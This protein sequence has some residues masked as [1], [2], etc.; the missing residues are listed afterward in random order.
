MRLNVV[1]KYHRSHLALD[2]ATRTVLASCD[3][4]MALWHLPD[5][6][7]H[8][9][10][11]LS[12]QF[13]TIPRW[14]LRAILPTR[15]GRSLIASD[16][17]QGELR[18]WRVQS[19]ARTGLR[20]AP[21]VSPDARADALR[22]VA[23]EGNA[24][25]VANA[26]DGTA[27]GPSVDLPQAPTFAS[28]TPDAMSLVAIA[29]P[30][31]FVFDAGTAAQRRPAAALPNDPVRVALNPDSHHLLLMFAEY[32][33]GKNEELAQIWNL[34]SGAPS[35]APVAFEF[36]S[37][38]HFSADGHTLLAWHGDRLELRDAQSLAT[39]PLARDLAG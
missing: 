10:Q 37:E 6:G 1:P 35:S 18:L 5:S 30:A 39:W 28:L 27:I 25:R 13:R 24:V 21:L 38:P 26:I 3:L 12:N 23:V 8:A 34:D 2:P 7:T 31:L 4:E 29:G 33:N 11:R 20:G 15:P 9:A 16:G 22:I 14:W 17:G 32:R 19:E 36:A